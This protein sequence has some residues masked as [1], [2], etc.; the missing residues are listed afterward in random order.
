MSDLFIQKLTNQLQ[1]KLP[2]K[3]A[4]NLMRI[5][6]KLLTNKIQNKGK[7]ILSSVLICLYPEKDN[8]YFF[9]TKR[10]ILVEHHKGQI[11]L[12]GGSIEEGES[13]EEASIRETNEE[14]GVL[15]DLIKIIGSLSSLYIPVSNF[16]I[17]P[18]IGWTEIK[19]E[20]IIQ[21]NEVAKIFSICVHDLINDKYQEKEERVFL[22]NKVLVPYFNFE[23]E[24]IWGATSIILSEFKHILREIL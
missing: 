3:T 17:F 10:S 19:P 15:P 7:K 9:I 23:S 13:P 24:K 12:P 1:K 8:W 4:H 22:N 2:G 6:S 11:S 20:I 14:I 5:E 21:K 18:F 16:K